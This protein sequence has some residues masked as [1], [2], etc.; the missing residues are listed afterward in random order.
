M[1]YLEKIRKIQIETSN[2]CNAS[3]I[4]CRRTDQATLTPKF[5]LK[6]MKIEFLNLSVFQKIFEDP[7]FADVEVVEFCG[8]IDEPLA[9]PEILKVIQLLASINPDLFLS[10][11]TNGSIRNEDFFIDLALSMGLFKKHELRFSIDGNKEQHLLYRG[12]VDYEKIFDNAKMFISYGGKA[13]WQMLTF[14]WNE[15]SV[16]EC[17]NKANELGF[18]KFVLRRDRTSAS[19]FPVNVI[20]DI[21]K[22]E[23]SS[24]PKLNSSEIKYPME[25]LIN[26][27]YQQDSMIFIDFKGNVLPCC[28]MANSDITRINDMSRQLNKEVVSKY[29]NGFNNLHFYSLSQVLNHEW[30]NDKL[31]KSWSNNFA[32]DNPRLIVCNQSCGKESPPL[33]KHTKVSNL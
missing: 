24:H 20:K 25:S 18:K 8:T 27:S 16:N 21:R 3:C 28:F 26:C 15:D 29:S 32:S 19:T 33:G 4:G 9:H 1:R 30:F 17:E 23:V 14:P 31:V 7:V 10:I 22:L 11:H 6:N 5:E 12:D 13:T 2:F